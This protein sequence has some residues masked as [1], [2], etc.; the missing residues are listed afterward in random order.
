MTPQQSRQL[1]ARRQPRH[2][3]GRPAEHR[4][5]DRR[6]AKGPLLKDLVRPHEEVMHVVPLGGFEETG[7]RNCLAVEY[8]G[9]VLLMDAGVMFPE[10][11]MP[12]VDYIIPDIAPLRGLE[13]RV[14]GVLVT[15]AHRDHIG[16]LPHLLPRLGNPPVYGAPFSIRQVQRH[17]ADFPSNPKPRTVELRAGSRTRIGP[18]EIEAVHEL[19]SIPDALG[20]AVRTP[21]GALF[22]SGDYR[23]DPDPVHDRQTDLAHLAQIGKRGVTAMLLESTGADRPGRGLSERTVL[24]NLDKIFAASRGRIFASLNSQML[25]RIQQL[26]GLAVKYRRNV[27]LEGFSLRMSVEIA[28]ELRYVN[29]PQGLIITTEQS[30]RLPPGRVLVLCTGAQAEE[31]SVLMRIVNREHRSLEIEPGD[32]IIFSSSVI[33][34][35]ERAIE[36]LKDFLARQGADVYHN[37]SMDIHASGHPSQEDLRE[38]IRAVR[39]EFFIPHHGNYFNRLLHGRLAQEVGIPKERVILPK[40]NGQVIEIRPHRVTLTNTVLPVNYIMVDGLGVGDVG[41]V[42]LRDRQILAD[43]GIV[44]VMVKRAHRSGALIG[45]PDLVSRG[46]VY[47]KEQGKLLADARK[48]VADIVRRTKPPKEG[49]PI[50]AYLKARIRDDLGQFL[51]SKTQRR[52]MIIPLLIEV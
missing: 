13:N 24:E 8:K 20:I 1:R 34:G 36:N 37:A 15:H 2:G 33:P 40:A 17:H 46:F 43:E 42:V 28:R 4:G 5:D 35:N 31:G 22:N 39:P 38:M 19:H 30:N 21:A 12:G 10:E 50:E 49:T 14:L 32:T 47:M 7:G 48:K 9:N 52:P 45:Q 18:F 29:V 23:L 11:D 25:N 6:P 3:R 27:V 51:F 26:L 41:E 16:A 44:V